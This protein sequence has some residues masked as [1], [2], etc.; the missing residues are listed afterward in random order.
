MLEMGIEFQL[1]GLCIRGELLSGVAK[2]F[3]LGGGELLK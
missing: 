3:L 2:L 1:K